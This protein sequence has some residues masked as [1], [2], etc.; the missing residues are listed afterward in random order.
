MVPASNLLS[1]LEI[2]R[3]GLWVSPRRCLGFDILEEMVV[4]ACEEI[5]AEIYGIRFWGYPR[6]DTGFDLLRARALA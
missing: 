1:S 3:A 6:W 5:D 4:V 2:S